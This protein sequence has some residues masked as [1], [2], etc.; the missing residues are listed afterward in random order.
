M[1]EMNEAFVLLLGFLLFMIYLKSQEK[2]SLANQM[3]KRFCQQNDLQFLDGTVAFRNIRWLRKN[4]SFMFGYRFEYS[5]N[6]VDRHTGYISL[7]G[8]HVQSLFIEPEHIK[9][10]EN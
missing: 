5:V 7:I 9:N 4:I 10:T 8:K 6:T 3:A 2:K 1:I